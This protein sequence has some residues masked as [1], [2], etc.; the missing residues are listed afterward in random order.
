MAHLFYG[1]QESTVQN[2]YAADEK[3]ISIL[4]NPEYLSFGIIISMFA[5]YLYKCLKNRRKS[6]LYDPHLITRIV[7]SWCSKNLCVDCLEY[8][9]SYVV[10]KR[11]IISIAKKTIEAHPKS[12]DIIKILIENF[13]KIKDTLACYQSKNIEENQSLTHPP[14]GDRISNIYQKGAQKIAAC[15]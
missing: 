9:T 11:A 14:L 15:A 10:L 6:L 8:I 4:E 12:P 1:H 7:S 3:A 2:E 5:F 13:E